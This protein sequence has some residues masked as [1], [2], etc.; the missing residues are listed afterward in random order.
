MRSFKSFPAPWAVCRRAASRAAGFTLIELLVTLAIFGIALTL[1][2]PGLL[3]M[4]QR[5]LLQGDGEQALVFLQRARFQAISRNRPQGVAFDASEGALFIDA[6]ADGVLDPVER[7]DGVF[8]A[9]RG[10]LFGGPPAE[11][12]AIAGFTTVGGRQV[13]LFRPDGAVVD[14]GGFRLHDFEGD[15]F[16]EVRVIEPATGLTRLRK[17]DG[18]AW[19]EQDEGGTS[20]SWN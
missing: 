5:R 8:V 2:I 10:V 17:W 3:A 15:D 11:P 7:R 1:A 16:L 19:R 13:A 4:R 12:E 14:A 20:W 9:S 18:T 6:N